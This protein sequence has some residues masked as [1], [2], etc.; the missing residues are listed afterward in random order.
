M[1]A[2]EYK[3][4]HIDELKQTTFLVSYLQLPKLPKKILKASLVSMEMQREL[5]EKV[6]GRGGQLFLVAMKSR[7]FV[8]QTL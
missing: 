3:A 7:D 8:R 1:V 5:V 6:T 2:M 4:S